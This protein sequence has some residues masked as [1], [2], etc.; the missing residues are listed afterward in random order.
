[1]IKVIL[2]WFTFVRRGDRNSTSRFRDDLM[3]KE[4]FMDPTTAKLLS[5]TLLPPF[6]LILVATL[7]LL[8]LMLR[9]PTGP[10]LLTASVAGLF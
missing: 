10:L 9:R 1:M 8:L 6:N 3:L 2:S 4:K 7:R 5:A